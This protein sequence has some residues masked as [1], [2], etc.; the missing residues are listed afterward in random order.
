MPTIT[1][2]SEASLT[3]INTGEKR[4]RENTPAQSK[5]AQGLR[6]DRD[7]QTRTEQGCARIA[8]VK[9]T[10]YVHARKNAGVSTRARAI[11][12]NKPLR[13]LRGR[14]PCG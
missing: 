3:R 4:L 8:R 2:H 1:C 14:I 5:D 11:L 13:S 6:K 12:V 9:V 7:R 10:Y